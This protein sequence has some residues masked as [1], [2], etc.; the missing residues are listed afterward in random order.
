MIRQKPRGV[1]LAQADTDLAAAEIELASQISRELA[2][3]PLP[4]S[5]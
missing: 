2:R 4:G 5:S 3:A 1:D